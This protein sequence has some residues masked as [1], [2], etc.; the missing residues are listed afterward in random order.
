MIPSVES[1]KS[2]ALLEKFRCKELK[3]VYILGCTAAALYIHAQQQRA[4][5]LVWAL[6]KEGELREGLNVAVVGGG[7][8]GLTAAIALAAS[9][10]KVTVFEETFKALSY[11]RGNLTRYVHPNV[12]RWPDDGSGY[13]ITHLP[14]MNWRAG[15]VGTVNSEIEAQWKIAK[16]FFEKT[17]QIDLLEETQVTD[18]SWNSDKKVVEVVANGNVTPFDLAVLAV[19]YGIEVSDHGVASYWH[20]DDFAQ[21]ILGPIAKKKYLVSGIGDGA[22][23]EIL[24]LKLNDFQHHNFID[25]VIFDP[26]LRAAGQKAQRDD[27]S[28]WSK[29]GKDLKEEFSDFFFDDPMGAKKSKIRLDT[30][31]VLVGDEPELHITRESPRNSAQILHRLCVKLLN[32]AGELKYERGRLA[33]FK[34]AYQKEG[35]AIVERHGSNK[36]IIP[37]LKFKNDK[38]PKY[39]ALVKKT[40]NDDTSEP[41]TWFP[42]YGRGYLSTELMGCHFED[43]YEIGIALTGDNE[44]TINKIEYMLNKLGVKDRKPVIKANEVAFECQD[45]TFTLQLQEIPKV[46]YCIPEESKLLTRYHVPG[47]F[48]DG[49]VLKTDAKKILDVL[50]DDEKLPYHMYRVYLT[51]DYPSDDPEFA[52]DQFVNTDTW[53]YL[54]NETK[55]PRHVTVICAKGMH[56][57]HEILRI[58][59]LVEVMGN[60]L[61]TRTVHGLGWAVKNTSKVNLE[62]QRGNELLRR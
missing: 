47:E 60:K 24:R 37:L 28:G 38:D 30:D 42:N 2:A 26:K 20:N 14:Y 57:A 62:S 5:N 32:D 45:G 12:A 7:M 16:R 8:A 55:A 50:F 58:P 4:F 49:L 36:S 44:V 61:P 52:L 43:R 1:K 34:N 40:K 41:Y 13:P 35:Y 10:A 33:Q 6:N 56:L 11:Q 18:V 15:I 59:F 31:V 19:G 46:S 9:K 3:S 22:L 27:W 54:F 29:V 25:S 39:V 17:K 48:P 21:P 53:V 51:K 23:T